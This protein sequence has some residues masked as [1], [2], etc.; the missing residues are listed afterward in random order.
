[1]RMN[2]PDWTIVLRGSWNLAL[3]TPEWV[4]KTLYATEELEVE[5]ALKPAAHRMRYFYEDALFI[6]EAERVI[7]GMR[8]YR[9]GLQLEN[10]AL[11]VRLLEELPH[12]PLVAIGVNYGFSVSE[13]LEPL[14][15]IFV[16]PDNTPLA[17][18]GFA[19]GET[20]IVRQ[21]R[22][23][24]HI[25]NLRQTLRDGEIHVH[26]NFHFPIVDREAAP[27]LLVGLTERT[28]TAA[29]TLLREI[30]GATFEEPDDRE[31]QRDTAP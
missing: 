17:E 12:T 23:D 8:R 10:E 22:K 13:P 15:A 2:V 30:Y 20:S 3:L 5:V 27:K 28:R 29:L 26:L 1:M 7:I 16:L 4:A 14:H 11:A 18:A 25:I 6:P 9:E 21:M 31:Q 24:D 19:L